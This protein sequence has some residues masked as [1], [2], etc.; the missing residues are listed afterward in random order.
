MNYQLGIDLGSGFSKAVLLGDR[1]IRTYAIMPSG[2]SYKET[3]E[4]VT[5]RV[6]REAGLS[7][8]DVS[9]TVAT[10]YGAAMV[11]FSDESV[12]DISCHAA[13]NGFGWK[14]AT[15]FTNVWVN[16]ESF[17]APV[18]PISRSHHEDHHRTLQD[19]SG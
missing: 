12:T 9:R 16:P 4:N 2:G 14:S 1:V 5:E 7:L 15:G 13:G 3:A 19:Q 8:T 6:L 18:R 10:G 11:D 17:C